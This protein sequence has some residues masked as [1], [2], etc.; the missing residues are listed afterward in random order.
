[1]QEPLPAYTFNEARYYLMVTVCGDCG[2]GPWEIDQAQPLSA[3]GGTVTI[4]THCK[5]CGAKQQFRFA[6]EHQLPSAIPAAE[7]INPT[8]NPSRI[9]DLGQWL[10]LFY[11]LIES[12]VTESSKPSVRRFG[13]QAALCL[14][15]AL[16]FYSDDELPP[17]TAFFSEVTTA[18][19]QQH[20]ENYARQ[21]LCDM[22]A[23]LPA[24]PKMAS[25]LARDQHTLKHKWWEFWRR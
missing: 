19:F 18:T 24:L 13:Y 7:C 12:A 22:Q 25:Q 17:Q 9:V 15:E 4:D 10:S 2:K 5:N 14:A 3:D 6:C 11:L 16:K 8:N 21:K 23:K 1:M 20:P